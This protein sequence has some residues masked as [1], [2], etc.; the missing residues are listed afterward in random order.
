MIMDRDRHSDLIR[1]V[2]STG[3][4][5]RLIVDGDVAGV[6]ATTQ[7]EKSASTFISALAARRKACSRLPRCAA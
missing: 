6:I 4:A 5:I 2:R 3:A 1:R 7:A